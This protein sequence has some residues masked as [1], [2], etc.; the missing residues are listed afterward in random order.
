MLFAMKKAWSF[1]RRHAFIV[2]LALGAVVGAILFVVSGSR[3]SS[4]LKA[5][6]NAIARERALHNEEVS[7]IDEIHADEV[8]AREAAAKRAVDAV[9]QAE[10][11]YR[12]KKKKLD[13][14]R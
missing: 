3:S 8:A 14:V 7:K 10:E 12:K 4:L 2:V 13:D 1:V 6:F 9:R 11:Q 5:S